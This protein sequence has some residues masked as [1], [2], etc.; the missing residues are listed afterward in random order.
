MKQIYFKILVQLFV[1]Q[2]ALFFFVIFLRI[3]LH[4]LDYLEQIISH[5]YWWIENYLRQDIKI[6]QITK[7][8]FVFQYLL[9]IL[10][11]D[12]GNIINYLLTNQTHLKEIKIFTPT[13]I[14]LPYFETYHLYLLD[15][16]P[17]LNLVLNFFTQNLPLTVTTT[18]VS[19]TYLSYNLEAVFDKFFFENN[20]I[21]QIFLINIALYLT[22]I[23]LSGSMEPLLKLLLNDSL[24]KNGLSSNIT[25]KHEFD[26]F[27]FWQIKSQEKIRSLETNL[28]DLDIR[29]KK[30]EHLAEITEQKNDSLIQYCLDTCHKTV[31]RFID[32]LHTNILPM[33][34]KDFLIFMTGW[35]FGMLFFSF[36]L[37]LGYLFINRK[38]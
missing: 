8:N 12:D 15:I 2:C 23:Y 4:N 9:I 22:C 3:I 32:V 30:L 20:L 16:K 13:L 31:L 7:I 25:S 26:M 34:N 29:L 17:Y 6:S 1:I 36:I 35:V 38:K 11:N 27:N 18:N 5:Y 19:I 33:I 21:Y 10:V 28:S 14:L 37:A 24:C